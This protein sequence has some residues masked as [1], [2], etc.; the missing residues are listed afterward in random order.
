LDSLLR[1]AEIELVCLAGFMRVL[2]ASLVAAWQDRMLNIHPSLLPLLP[3][4]DTHRRALASGVKI[5]GATVHFVRSEVDGGP[6]VAQGA[7][8]VLSDDTA[9]TLAARVLRVEHRVYPLA[10]KLVAEGRARVEGDRV[11]IAGV[12]ASL[13][14][15]LIS[16]QD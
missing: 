12:P 8:P 6:I 3:G 16:P 5:H 4:L 9:D 15:A 14:A 10:L 11:V 13:E 7:V 1:G 2:G